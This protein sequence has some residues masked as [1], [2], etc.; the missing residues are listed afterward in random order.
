MRYLFLVC[1]LCNSI[2]ANAQYNIIYENSFRNWAPGQGW[3]MLNN[4][5]IPK[6]AGMIT[7]SHFGGVPVPFYLEIYDYMLGVDQTLSATDKIMITPPLL[8]GDSTFV[9]YYSKCNSGSELSLWVLPFHNDTTQSGL[10]DSLGNSSSNGFNVYNLSAYSGDTVRLAFRIRGLITKG[11]IDNLIVLDKYSLAWVPDVNFR[12]YLKTQI[13][14]AFTG[15]SLDFL[16]PSVINLLQIISPN[17]QINTL[18]GLQYFV[19]LKK[20]NVANNSI[21]YIP[22]DKLTFLDSA[23]AEN[24]FLSF[25][26]DAPL[27]TDLRLNNNLIKNI[28]DIKNGE[29]MGLQM[30]NNLLY[31]CLT[32]SNRW[33][34]CDLT[35]NIFTTRECTYYNAYFTPNPGSLPPPI[36][37]PTMGTIKG[38]SYYDINQNSSYDISDIV[39]QNQQINFTQGTDITTFADGS[40][41]IK[42]DSGLVNMSLTSL[43]AGFIC[44]TPLIDTIS[45]QEVITHDF[46]VTSTSSFNDLNVSLNATGTTRLNENLTL[47]LQVKNLGTAVA[48]GVV[49]MYLPPGYTLI[50]LQ[51]GSILNDTLSWNINLTPFRSE[52]NLLTIRVDSFPINQE[53]FFNANL[54]TANDINLTNNTDTVGVMIRDSLVTVNPPFGFPYDPNNKLVDHPIV[55]PGFQEYLTYNINFENIGTGNASRVMVRDYLSGKLDISTFELLSTSHPCIV[56]FGAD[57]ILQFLFQPIVLTPTSIDPINSHGH[58]WFKIKPKNPIYLNDTIYNSAGIYFDLQPPILTNTSMVYADTST[59]VQFI[60]SNDTLCGSGNVQ[61]RNQSGGAPLSIEWQFPG[62]NPITSTLSSPIVNYNTPGTYDVI[63]IAKYVG[64]NDTLFNPFFI[65]VH[66]VTPATII[67]NGNDSICKGDSVLLS[68][69]HPGISYQWWQTNQ[70]TPSI[71]ASTSAYYQLTITDSN[72]CGSLA[73]YIYIN[74]LDPSP[75]ITGIDTFCSGTSTSLTTGLFSSYLW[76]NGAT[77]RTTSVSSAGLYI[78]TVTNSFGCTGV[79]SIYMSQLNALKPTITGQDSIC[80]G[81]S[82]QLSAG[83]GYLGYLWSTGGST[84]IITV[85]NPGA[86]IVTVTDSLGCQNKDTFQLSNIVLNPLTANADS[87]CSGSQLI[88]DAGAGYIQYLWNT[89]DTT[90]QILASSPGYYSVTVEDVNGCTVKDSLFLSVISLPV[91][92]ISGS[93]TLC[94]GLPLAVTNTYSSYSWSNGGTANSIYP[95]SS[96]IY[97]VTVTDQNGCT[98]SASKNVTVISSP[99][100]IIS[101]IDTVCLGEPGLLITGTYLSYLWSNGSTQQSIDPTIAGN[102][103]VTVT[104]FNGCTGID[105]IEFVVLNLPNPFITGDDTICIGSQTLLDAGAGFISYQWSTQDSSSQ[106]VVSN[107]GTYWVTVID[108]FGCTISVSHQLFTSTVDTSV[109]VTGFTLLSLANTASWQWMYCDSSIINGANGISFTATQN[110]SYAVIVSENGCTDTSSCFPINVTGFEDLKY[111]VAALFPNPATTELNW[112]GIST[113][114]I[115]SISI[116]SS[117]G[118]FVKNIVVDKSIN[119]I[120]IDVSIFSSGMYYLNVSLEKENKRIKFVVLHD[121]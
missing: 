121:E 32:C 103:L 23:D 24:N 34:L 75:V 30:K 33:V 42:V 104:D 72:G 19:S 18:E 88:I 76:S 57:S 64:H 105:S 74:V 119:I 15:D 79:D 40:Y 66:S 22:P 16:A 8:I 54:T 94:S 39:L 62:G 106:I 91:P 114:N 6:S 31:D 58:I 60:V 37:G 50:N 85:N 113:D 3:V 41:L 92:I 26:P 5:T 118:Q 108:S 53:I 97:S 77:T 83:T 96:G 47:S 101:G 7:N 49:K 120:K 29:V 82:T 102:Y 93:D 11:F 4:D 38:K 27:C 9:R 84:P 10:T 35:S 80:I 71:Y 63:L 98:G 13:P 51:K 95:T 87:I 59:G 43:P 48:S 61:F 86:Y 25:F 107:A 12:N 1:I 36:C 45:T 56:S 69:S 112:S 17:S 99:V 109:N 55:N 70:T 73:P 111:G 116:Y 21:T 67:L 78:V 28:P 115:K 2:Y 44:N 81:S 100:P 14:I 89:G 110:G 117:T 90:Q 68:A 20:L 52:N 46:I 65:Q